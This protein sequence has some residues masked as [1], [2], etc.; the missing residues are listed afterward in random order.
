[1]LVWQD[2]DSRGE[3][4]HSIV[5]LVYNLSHPVHLSKKLL[6]LQFHPVITVHETRLD[7]NIQRAYES[8]S[9]SISCASEGSGGEDILYDQNACPHQPQE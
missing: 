9:I 2:L 6:S 3:I 5:I 4:K 8:V 7:D 1:M